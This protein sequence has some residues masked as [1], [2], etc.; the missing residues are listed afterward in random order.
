M[1]EKKQ[2]RADAVR[3]WILVWG[4]GL[5]AQFCW[6]LENMW[7]NSFVYA[8]IGKD[9][10]I[11]TGMM[12]CSAAATTFSTFFF[13]TWSDRTGNRRTFMSVGYIIWGIFTI[14]FGV[15]EFIPKSM[16]TL[17]AVMVVLADTVM[18]FF[19]SMAN[20][21]TYNAWTN[22]IMTDS[23]RGQIGAALGTLPILGTLL[24]TLLGAQ[25]VGSNDN[26]MRLFLVIGGSVSVF[27]VISLFV[28]NKG[29]DVEPSK[30]GTF[31]KQFAS[32]FNFKEFFRRKELIWVFVAL[33]FLFSGYY[34]VAAYLNN[35]LI[36]YLGFNAGKIGVIE[37]VPMGVAMLASIPASRAINRNKHVY[38]SILG[39][40]L[41]AVGCF[42]LVPLKSSMVDPSHVFN[43]QLWL[44]IFVLTAG[45]IIFLQVSRV[46]AKQLYPKDARGQFE[47][48]WILFVVL[49]PMIFGS[50]LGQNIVKT[51]GEVFRDAASGQ[52]QY[53]PNGSIFLAAGIVVLVSIIPT[54]FAA[55]HFYARIGK[56]NEVKTAE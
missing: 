21:S 14:L 18:S 27:G 8:K 20:D 25:L 40:V 24:G 3:M 28:M 29:D 54:V 17:A 32:V 50:I 1:G 53:I 7:F 51:S 26:Y 36:Y 13:G 44:G 38:V 12:I 33:M 6:N 31:W 34:A 4:L 37:A 42:I 9:P 49:F 19:G 35:Y 23:N 56:K 55:R 46:W 22:D 15:T 16:Y 47:G 43:L 30:R 10:A 39:S 52:M 2:S 5:V 41:L 45:Y 11:I 48:I